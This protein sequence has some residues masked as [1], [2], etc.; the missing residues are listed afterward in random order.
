MAQFMNYF[1]GNLAREAG[2]IHG[3]SGKFWH[4]QYSCSVVADDE[5][6]QVQVLR[7]LLSHGCKEGLVASPLHWPGLHPAS[8]IQDGQAHR[9][10][11][12]NRTALCRARHNRPA[13]PPETLEYEEEEVL[14]LAQLPCWEALSWEEYQARVRALVKEI[15]EETRARHRR[16]GTRPVG[17]RRVLRQNPRG[18]P[19][20][21]KKGPGPLIIAAS[22][23]VQEAFEK[24]YRRVVEA[25]QCAS[26]KLRAGDRWAVFPEGT[27]P[28]ALAFV[29]SVALPHGT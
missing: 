8:M 16:H 1:A 29:R 2:R 22:K 5:A 27:F 11:W 25:Y 7:Y 23:A 26:E 18:A 6:S 9:G 12:V 19:P 24:A 21:P 3:W 14:R 28:P 4:R 20:K 15:E 17:R 10:I 13:T